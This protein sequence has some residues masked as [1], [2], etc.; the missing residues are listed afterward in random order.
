MSFNT[1]CKHQKHFCDLRAIERRRREESEDSGCCVRNDNSGCLQTTQ[2][3]CSKVL[4]TFYKW[5]RYEPGPDGRISGP[6]CGQ[7]PRFC[8]LPA[9]SAPHVWADNIT[10]W[11]VCTANIDPPL[12][13]AFYISSLSIHVLP[14]YW[15]I[16]YDTLNIKKSFFSLINHF[17]FWA[18]FALR[19]FH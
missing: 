16:H 8:S 3:K 19:L 13:S 6:V 7:D 12:V 5:T 14:C 2:E 15:H 11:P 4:S 1:V 10:M 17:N 18:F 9:S